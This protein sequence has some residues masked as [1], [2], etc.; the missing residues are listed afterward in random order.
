MTTQAQLQAY[1]NDELDTETK[2]TLARLIEQDEALQAQLDE[3]AS[4]ETLV[5]DAIQLIQQAPTQPVEDALAALKRRRATSP[6]TGPQQASLS[7]VQQLLV[8]WQDPMFTGI[9]ACAAMALVLLPMGFSSQDHVGGAVLQKAKPTS[10]AAAPK[11]HQLT[12]KGARTSSVPRR[13]FLH[14]GAL[15]PKGMVSLIGD[16]DVLRPEQSLLFTMVLQVDGFVYLL[17]ETDAGVQVLFPFSKGAVSLPKGRH[18][19]QHKG[20]PQRYKLRRHKG[21][22]AFVLLHSPTPLTHGFLQRL[23]RKEGRLDR[24][25]LRQV[26]PSL[27]LDRIAMKVSIPQTK[28]A[29]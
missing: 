21:K 15:Q 14:V 28:E 5:L 22:I 27:S 10:P 6:S 18:V 23:P 1:L 29:Q 25:S 13:A 16:G 2:A 19:L 11:A 4:Q 9:M 17:L 8:W 12:A 7:F 24:V 26:R 20:V 3:I